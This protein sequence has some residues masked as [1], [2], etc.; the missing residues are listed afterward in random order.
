MN[1]R[2]TARKVLCL[3]AILCTG[4]LSVQANTVN[5]TSWQSAEYVNIP[6]NGGTKYNLNQ[7][8]KKITS[9]ST[10]SMKASYGAFLAPYARF[11]TSGKADRSPAVGVSGSVSHPKLYSTVNKGNVL[12]TKMS[13]NNFDPGYI[14]VSL[15]F[16]ADHI[17]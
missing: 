1:A 12:Y 10:A 5:G 9:S 2:K 13:T 3:S 4:I 16:A 8:T 17:D 15:N 14:E 6:P 11:I 7:G